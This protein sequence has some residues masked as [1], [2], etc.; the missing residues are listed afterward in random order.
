MSF[1]NP[2]NIAHFTNILMGLARALVYLYTLLNTV[3]MKFWTTTQDIHCTGHT[4]RLFRTDM[5][6]GLDNKF[7]SCILLPITP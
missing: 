5:N 4:G 1:K 7:N 3:R 6:A 2:V